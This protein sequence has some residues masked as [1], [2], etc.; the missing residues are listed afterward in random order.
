MLYGPPSP[1]VAI[2]EREPWPLVP[3]GLCLAML[4]VLGLTLPAPVEIL[5]NRIVE[6]TR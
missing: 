6:I 1:G 4:V 2:G 3:L 5:L